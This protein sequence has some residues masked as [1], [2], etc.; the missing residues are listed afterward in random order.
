MQP[1]PE[2]TEAQQAALDFAQL[3]REASAHFFASMT[4]RHEMGEKK[5][6]PIKFMEVN[7]LEEAMEEVVD[8]A[9]Y[10]M[11][12]YLK[13]WVLNAQQQKM[14]KDAPDMLGPGSFMSNGG[15]N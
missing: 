14:V 3:T 12:T 13:L 9:N 1:T 8:L 15:R 2:P 10:A 6:G 4:E 5:Y 11:Y 7:T